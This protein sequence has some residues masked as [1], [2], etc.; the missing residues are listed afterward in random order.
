MN[1]WY[2][3]FLLEE[4]ETSKKGLE[5]SIWTSKR[6]QQ[7]NNS[8]VAFRKNFATPKNKSFNWR[9]EL[10][11]DN[12]FEHTYNIRTAYVGKYLREHTME[13]DT[14]DEWKLGAAVGVLSTLDQ[15]IT[16]KS[17]MKEVKTYQWEACE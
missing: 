14:W 13:N 15:L 5:E 9:E 4:I 2:S 1:K 8:L 17:I 10:S 12:V 3:K 6:Q 7:L 16:D 11:F